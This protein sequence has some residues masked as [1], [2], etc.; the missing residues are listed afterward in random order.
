MSEGVRQARRPAIPTLLYALACTL[1]A[2][3]AILVEG[4]SWIGISGKVAI[5][6]AT[7]LLVLCIFVHPFRPA[8][9][10]IAVSLM[11][12]IAVASLCLMRQESVAVALGST[13]TSCWTFE[14]EEDSKETSRGYRCRARAMCEGMP[15]GSVWLVSDEA[16]D[17][18]TWLRCSGRFQRL[19]DDEWGQVSR[20]QG[21]CGTVSAKRIT[22]TGDAQGLCGMICEVRRS[23][24]EAIDPCRDDAR[25]LVAGC[26]CGWRLELRAKGLQDLFG[27][28][29]ASHLV[30]VSGG[31]LAIMAG[32]LD[33]TMRKARLRP[34]ARAVITTITSGLF[35]FMCGMP[36]SAV[37]AWVMATAS[38]AG[39]LLGRRT[40]SL[41][42]VCAVGLVMAL[43]EP[44]LSGSVSFLLSVA[45]VIGLCVYGAYADYAIRALFP[46]HMI[47]RFV[48]SRTRRMLRAI[49]TGLRQ[50]V[51]TS[52]VAQVVTLPLV[53]ST[54][55]E[56]SLAGPVAN[57]I[58]AVPF[59]AMQ[60]CGAVA[61]VFLWMPPIRDAFF[62]GANGCARA[63]LGV[64]RAVDAMSLPVLRTAGATIPWACV[65]FLVVLLVTWPKVSQ[66]W[67]RAIF[68]S[69]FC[70]MTLFTA[71]WRLFAP[72]RI[73]VLDV[74]QGDAILVQDG[75]SAV[76]VDAGPDD[77]VLDALAR[78][79]VMHLN[80]VIITHLHDDHYGGVASLAGRVDCGQVIVAKG[81][82]ERMNTEA[83][84]AIHD[85]VGD[86]VT[87]VGYGDI[88][89]VGSFRMRVVSP[90]MEVDGDENGESLVLLAIYDHGERGLTALLT[91][92]AEQDVLDQMLRRGDLNDVDV[93]KVGHHGSEISITR[94][95]ACAI[96]PEV[97]VASAGVHNR[98]GHPREE[99]VAV[100][101]ES[102]SEFWCTKDVGDVEVRPGKEDVEVRLQR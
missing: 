41:S 11:V 38:L 4:R 66:K 98:Y 94:E 44:A 25:A 74:G 16:Y 56:T 6:I 91:G 1:I 28:C 90:V 97:S 53:A 76:L 8:G 49:S 24:L 59:S 50:S 64:L 99:C 12:A 35:V 17:F 84:D 69:A 102:G 23:L 7:M 95:Q 13:S 60:A 20:A 39:G 96:D 3:R 42:C 34:L 68:L 85:L 37:R 15:S 19:G 72:A 78:T 51:A 70:A 71:R 73:T 29:G 63:T 79:H 45:S 2:E 83:G 62:I 43:A 92:D 27:R 10:L 100:L 58:V 47:P 88:I 26:L 77:A 54:I 40:H 52:V 32:M 80:A 31:H 22:A 46:Q 82:R 89:H 87:E 93:L 57:A 9:S 48:P 36:A 81:V 21:I 65:V 101:K 55:G 33:A 18:D 61:G 14:I 75:A 86:D 67:T 30:A 5:G